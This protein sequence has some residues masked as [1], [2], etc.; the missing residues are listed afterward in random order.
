MEQECL[1]ILGFSYKPTEKELKSAY[2]KLVKQ[3]HPDV[4]GGET[5]REY[6]KIDA[7]YKYLTGKINYKEAESILFPEKKKERESTYQRSYNT[8]SPYTPGNTYSNVN[9][10]EEFFREFYRQHQEEFDERGY[11]RNRYYTVNLAWLRFLPLILLLVFIL[12]VFLFFKTV[13]FV[14]NILFSPFGMVLIAIYLVWLVFFKR[15]N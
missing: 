14:L 3:H 13:G 10:E 1:R 5:S 8:G 11:Y 7:A 9:F 6:L 12:F 15:R 2:K 4:T